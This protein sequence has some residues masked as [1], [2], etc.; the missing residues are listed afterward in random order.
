MVGVWL[1]AEVQQMSKVRHVA[2]VWL[3]NEVQQMGGIW[4]IPRSGCWRRW[5]RYLRVSPWQSSDR[6]LKSEREL[7]LVSRPSFFFSSSSAFPVRSLGFTIFGWDF[8]ACDIW[9]S[10]IPSSWMVHAGC[11]F[12]TG[13]HPSRTW[14]SGSFESVR[15]NACVHRLDFGLYSHPKEFWGNGV[16]THVNSKGKIPS[17]GKNSPQRRIEPTTPHQ[18]GQRARHSTNWA[19]PPPPPPPT[20]P[21]RLLA[22]V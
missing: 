5:S 19:I 4:Q 9:G 7:W 8:C 14:T 18:A 11:V 6:P 21:S 3:R 1:M 2:G 10:H 16:G 13:I 22:D 12:V 20:T 17:T 15:W